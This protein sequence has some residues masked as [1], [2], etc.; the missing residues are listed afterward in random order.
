MADIPELRIPPRIA[1]L[2]SVEDKEAFPQKKKASW[3]FSVDGEEFD[4]IRGKV[5]YNG[6]DLSQII[7]QRPRGQTP[8]FWTFFAKRLATYRD[9]A[10]LNVDEPHQLAE[11]LALMQGYLT[12]LYKR[13]KKR[14]DETLDGI[15]FLLEDGELWI[16]GVNVHACL[17]MAKDCR[18][19]QKNLRQVRI[20][21]KGLRSRLY[22]LQ[23]NRMGNSNYEKIRP[24]VES[25]IAQLGEEIE[26]IL[27]TFA[28]PEAN[29]PVSAV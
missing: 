22:V 4:F 26:K 1:R 6:K 25:L 7:K 19:Q 29:L 9:W 12:E 23:S 10:R 11:F 20:F 17:K 24:T 5:L 14:F 16:N 2:P 15:G 8:D 28:L 18:A 3:R 13:I 21:L 27:D